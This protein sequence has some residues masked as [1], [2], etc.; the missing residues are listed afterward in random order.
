M[1]YGI[2]YRDMNT[3]IHHLVL[4]KD[5]QTAEESL[6][7]LKTAK[8]IDDQDLYNDSIQFVFKSSIN[9]IEVNYRELTRIYE[10]Y[11]SEN[12]N[13]QVSKYLDEVDIIN[14]NHSID[15]Y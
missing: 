14:F 10:T 6:E 7:I 1:L 3:A 4:F 8:D 2:D 9:D 15:L 5:K 12:N 13:G 11:Y